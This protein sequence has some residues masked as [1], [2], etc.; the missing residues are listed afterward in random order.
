MRICDVGTEF[1]KIVCLI[2]LILRRIRYV[3]VKG[4]RLSA[5]VGKDS[6]E[7]TISKTAGGFFFTRVT[8]NIS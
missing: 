5:N 4:F 1:L 8:T 3:N 7:P 2:Y 6:N